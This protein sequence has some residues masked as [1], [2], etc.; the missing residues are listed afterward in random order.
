MHATNTAYI[1]ID[2]FLLGFYFASRAVLMN[3]WLCVHVHV[4][5][6]VYMLLPNVCDSLLQ[7]DEH[8]STVSDNGS[9]V[10]LAC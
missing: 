1:C 7:D 2:G 3:C 4:C 5:I 9:E 6:V 10:K 8:N